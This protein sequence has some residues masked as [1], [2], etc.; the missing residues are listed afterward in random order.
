MKNIIHR[1]LKTSNIFVGAEGVCKIADFG[2]AIKSESN[3]KDVC[4]GSP[5]YMAP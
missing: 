2:F 5:L 4:L 1:D 3:F